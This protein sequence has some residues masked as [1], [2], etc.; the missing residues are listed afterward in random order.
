M[1]SSS[2][3]IYFI[4]KQMT[5]HILPLGLG[6]VAV[7][8][9]LL[10]VALCCLYKLTP[11]LAGANISKVGF[12]SCIGLPNIVWIAIVAFIAYAQVHDSLPAPFNLRSDDE[13]HA[14]VSDQ[15]RLMGLFLSF[16]VM[17]CCC[18]RHRCKN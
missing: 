10:L 12:L 7:S 5:H 1:A 17:C 8:T 9:F 18:C 11:Y 13:E 2:F 14:E 16:L 6:A 15:Q 3:L 4:N